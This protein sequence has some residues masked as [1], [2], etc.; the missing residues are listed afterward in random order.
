MQKREVGWQIGTSRSQSCSIHLPAA[1]LERAYPR[2]VPKPKGTGWKPKS[3]PLVLPASLSLFSWRMCV[4]RVRASRPLHLDGKEFL[5]W[6]GT[7]FLTA[8]RSIWG[9]DPEILY[10]SVSFRPSQTRLWCRTCG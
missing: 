2:G 4:Q 9:R 3:R 5:Y 10:R 6:L 7:L 1:K 8:R